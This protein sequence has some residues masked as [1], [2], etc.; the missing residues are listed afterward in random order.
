MRNGRGVQEV[1]RPI[2]TIVE[3]ESFCSLVSILELYVEQT[4]QSTGTLARE[5][6]HGCS[7][8]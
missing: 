7:A 2:Q 3:E 4:D 6:K 8:E 1:A 5:C